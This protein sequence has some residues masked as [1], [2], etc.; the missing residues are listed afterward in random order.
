M[1]L[2]RFPKVLYPFLKKNT[3]VRTVFYQVQKLRDKDYFCKR[4]RF[5][6][7]GYGTYSKLIKGTNNLIIVG[8]NTRMNQTKFQI[9]GNN[10]VI[11]IGDNCALGSNC[12]FCIEGN[13]NTIS[14]G[15]NSTFVL[16]CHFNAQ[17]DGS[18]IEVGEDCMFSNHIIVRTSDSHPI[19]DIGSGTRIN[20][21]KPVKIGNHV[22]IAPDTKIMK[23]AI[24]GDGC[25]IGSNTMI[26]KEVPTSCLVVGMPGKVIKSN[27]RWT[28]DDI[29]FHS[30]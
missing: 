20:P 12:S 23:G 24:I 7:K 14:I 19:Y 8:A 4:A 1:F 17:E 11:R 18:I 13:G 10:N 26:S 3:L 6:N 25:I 29:I 28:R 2:S 21:A 27:V 15:N 22:W 16:R 5:E 9:Y 30:N